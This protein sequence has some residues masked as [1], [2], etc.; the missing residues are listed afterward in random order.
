MTKKFKIFEKKYSKGK[1]KNHWEHYGFFAKFH[2]NWYSTKKQFLTETASTITMDMP[3][4]TVQL[5]F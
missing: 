3:Y 5:Y 4:F 1:I 2:K